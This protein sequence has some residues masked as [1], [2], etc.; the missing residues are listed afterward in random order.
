MCVTLLQK[1]K[2]H[3]SFLNATETQ[4][5]GGNNDEKLVKLALYMRLR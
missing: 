2:K 4:Y 3:E 1:E 5:S